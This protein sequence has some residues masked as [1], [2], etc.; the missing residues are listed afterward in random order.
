M[1]QHAKDD[2]RNRLA[3][4]HILA[5]ELSLSREEYEDVIFTIAR[6]RSAADL[7]HAGQMRVIE[8][9]VSRVNHGD[10]WS[11]IDRAAEERRPLLRKIM[12]QLKSASRG[13]PYAD[14]IARKMF[15]IERLELCGT[16]Q[17]HRLVAALEY[18]KRRHMKEAQP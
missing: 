11:W 10:D 8:H 3:R 15:G 18:D 6:V 12:M 13:K 1:K 4:I 17:L 5:A 14:G 16:D 2:R 9:L 7:D